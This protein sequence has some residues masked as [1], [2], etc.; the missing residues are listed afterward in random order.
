V[1]AIAVLLIAVKRSWVFCGGIVF[2]NQSMLLL[3]AIA[4]LAYSLVPT[5]AVEAAFGLAS[6]FFCSHFIR[7]EF[8]LNVLGAVLGLVGLWILEEPARAILK[9][10]QVKR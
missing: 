5:K 2:D 4:Y 1:L 7:Q 10:S 6:I 8:P 9:R 3:L